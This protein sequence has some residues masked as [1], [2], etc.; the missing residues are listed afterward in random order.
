[1]IQ[2][3]AKSDK[4][5]VRDMNQDYYY[6][7]NSLDR[8][9]LYILADGMGGYNGGE[10]ASNLAVKT[11]KNYIENNFKDIPKDRDSIIQLVGSSMEYA[12]MIVYEKSKENPELQGMGTTLEICLIYNNK[13][14][15]GHVGD[16]RIYRIRKDFIR[17]LTTDHSYV[18]KLVKEGTITKEQA[19]HH[20]QKNM[21]MKALGCNAFV[22]PDVMVKGFLKDDVLIICSD[23]LSNLV[24]QDTIKEIAK[25]KN[26]E[27]AT[28]DLVNR[29]NDRG[30]Y[31]NV[32]VVL[33]KNI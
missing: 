30:G 9:Q 15:I 20:P 8:I 27:Q 12:N 18:Q 5:K 24:E 14:Y 3:Y 21:L 10:I 17:K 2:A 19:A 13:A 22:E 25:N 23:G 11:A 32:T 28:K 6:I 33:I 1:M 16:S 7:S 4:G 26:I 31:D 29:A